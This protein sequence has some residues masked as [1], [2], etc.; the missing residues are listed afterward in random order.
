MSVVSG[1]AY[2]ATSPA[3][4]H[5]D[6]V[7]RLPAPALGDQLVSTSSLFSSASFDTRLKALEAAYAEEEKK[8]GEENKDEWKDASK[9][10][11]SVKIGG[12]FFGDYVLWARQNPTNAG[13]F[14]DLQNYFEFRRLRLCAEGEGYGVYDYELE[15]DFEPEG[16]VVENPAVGLRDVY[17]G[18]HDVPILGYVRFGHFKEPFSLEE[19]TSS[20]YFSFL[21]RALPNIFAPA[22]SV[23]VCAYNHTRDEQF[24]LACGAFFN[25]LGNDALERVGDNQGIDV[26]MRGTWS[27]WYS[28]DGR[29][30]LHLGGGWI[31]TDDRDDAVQFA[32]A[33]EV[34]ESPKFVDTGVFAASNL[35]RYNAEAALVYGPF[36]LQGELFYVRT[37]GIGATPNM[38]FYGAYFCGSFFLTGENRVYKRT[39]AAF[40]RVKPL[41]NFWIVRTDDGSCC[42]GWGAWELT[43]RWSYLDLS[44]PGLT[45]PARGTLHDLT[46]G[47][48]WYWHPHTRVMFNWIHA[49]NNIAAVGP[50][51]AD[52][53][54]MRM[55][56]DF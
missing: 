21:E 37:N 11:F 45:D 1:S 41:T 27:P 34:H 48:N 53:I 6:I 51:N 26:T 46:F 38:D 18:I 16:G 12:R 47:V 5:D 10:K 42:W 19:L 20:N 2:T 14:G 39:A 32:S 24:T 4:S 56:L 35:W 23:G 33:P 49:L 44:E 40:S 25:N 52:A 3:A 8:K 50:N 36:S 17:L 43:G 55:Q 29:G 22:R 15:V 28:C 30:V 31:F 7:T 9:E 13:Y 54:S